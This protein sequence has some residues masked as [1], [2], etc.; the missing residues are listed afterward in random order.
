MSSPRHGFSL[1]ELLIVMALVV[2]GYAYMFG[3][4][5]AWAQGRA[6]ARCAAQLQQMH[7]ALTLFAA[8]HDGAFPD[9]PTATTSE[10][11]LSQ[12]VPLYTTDTS[13]FI[14]PGSGHAA[15]TGA[16]P[17]ASRQCSY[18]YVA[19]LKSD[20][21]HDT[22]LAS[23]GQVSTQ[24]KLAGEPLFSISGKAPGNN[25]RGFGG[26]LLFVDGHLEQQG[27]GMALRDFAAPAGARLLNPKP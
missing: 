22:P 6:K 24:A 3:P 13:I 20:A 8:E 19:G 4:G 5:T 14:C 16:Q 26:N 7:A 23:D 2:C 27:D 25:H 15:L 18:A 9:A 12:L 10:P 1:V 11:A 17:F 21:G